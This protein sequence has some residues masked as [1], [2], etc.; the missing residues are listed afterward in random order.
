MGMEARSVALGAAA[1]TLGQETS[2]LT[3]E[4]EAITHDNNNNDNND[5]D[6]QFKIFDN[7][8]TAPRTVFNLYAQVARVQSCAIHAQHIKHLSHA[9]CRG[10][11]HVVRK[12]SSAIKLDR[13]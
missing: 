13:V 12:D 9:T 3:M 5:D 8:I 2:S 7:L 1:L 4:V 11:C 10:V 6:A